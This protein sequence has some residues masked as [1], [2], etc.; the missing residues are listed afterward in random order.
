MRERNVFE[1][2]VCQGWLVH[3]SE[4]ITWEEGTW[5]QISKCG[6][7]VTHIKTP[8]GLSKDTP[9]VEPQASSLR[10]L[11]WGCLEICILKLLKTEVLN[12]HQYG[13]PLV[14]EAKKQKAD[15][16]KGETQPFRGGV[17]SSRVRVASPES[18]HR[19]GEPQTSRLRE[20][21]SFFST[22]SRASCYLPLT[23]S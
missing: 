8:K 15:T 11:W 1:P 6:P 14:W 2:S 16:R 21:R 23:A 7:W 18:W 4:E 13:H 19:G 5:R 9:W 3:R 12:S 17:V 22:S 10:N 20:A